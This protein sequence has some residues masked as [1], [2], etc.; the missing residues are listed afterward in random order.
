[1]SVPIVPLVQEAPEGAIERAPAGAPGAD[2]SP[3]AGGVRF[4]AWRLASAVLVIFLALTIAFITIRYL[5]GNTLETLLGDTARKFSPEQEA[6]AIEQLGLNRPVF[7]QYIDYLFNVVRGDFGISYYQGAP[8]ST[9]IMGQIGATVQLTFSALGLAWI[10]S[11]IFVLLT[12]GRH[13]VVDGSA[14]FIEVVLASVPQFWLGLVLLLTFAFGLHWFPVVSGTS[15]TG[16]VLPAFTLALPLAGLLSQLTR[17]AF[18]NVLTQP[19]V[20]SARAR[21]CGDFRVR[22]VH[23]LRHA[24][25]PAVS[26]TGQSFGSMLGGTLVVEEIFARQGIGQIIFK[27]IN[28]RDLPLVLGVV[29]VVALLYVVINVI[30]DI[31]QR[32]IDPR[33][34]QIER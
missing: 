10:I 15:V 14:R 11:L 30:V 9:I 2:R 16:L 5:P 29:I 17:G 12:T 32:I 28:S 25:T 3:L 23:V 21:G 7:E 24:I 27:A 8:V 26:V 19:F 4:L 34:A 18:E 6:A 31:L 13:A 33:I 1:M 22:T 20:L